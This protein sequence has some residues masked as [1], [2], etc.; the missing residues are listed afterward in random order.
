MKIA[1]IISIV[2]AV[3]AIIS[4]ILLMYE[5]VSKYVIGTCFGIGAIACFSY[6]ILYFKI[7]NNK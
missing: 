1:K 6:A 5:D 7:D 4:G 2:I 3:A